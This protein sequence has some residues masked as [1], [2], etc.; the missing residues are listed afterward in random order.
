MTIEPPA[1]GRPTEGDGG[2]PSVPDDVW[3]RFVHDHEEDIRASAPVE[4]SARAR[5]VTARLRA[6]DEQAASAAR[7]KGL[8]RLPGARR[9][10]D[11]PPAQ[12]PG[13]RT[14]P[15]W[16]EMN[17]KA[18][19]KRRLRGGIG[20]LAAVAVVLFALN[21]G[22]V[23]SRLPGG[24]GKD[25]GTRPRDAAPL[26]AETARPTG[27][28]GDVPEEAPTLARPF[29]GS[30]A[31][32]YADGAAGIVLPEPRAVGAMSKDQVAAALQRTKDFLVASGLDPATLR[33]ERPAAALALLDPRQEDVS[34]FA[35]ASLARPDREH[36]PVLL[37]TRFDPKEA[38]LV[39]PTV[40]TR[41]RITFKEGK[42]GGVTVHADYTFVYALR[43][44]ARGSKEV[45][46]TIVRRVLDTELLDPER[47]QVTP[48]RLTLSSFDMEAGNS[49]CGRYDG[50]LHPVFPST[51]T[52]GHEPSGPAVDPYDRSRELDTGD[53]A[54]GGKGSGKTSGKDRRAECGTVSRS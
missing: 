5:M 8:G 28:P 30:P 38:V 48:D 54:D 3:E 43:K 53:G 31:Q 39:G 34:G 14:G 20:V 40:K 29:A 4:P 13:W 36:D 45:T 44:P 23:L 51:R 16:Q 33:G 11:V 37:F 26:A 10:K 25:D 15:A 7:R 46:R 22:A 47:Y 49:A 12:P 24:P 6:Q 2:R 35:T 9:R 21:P 32:S 19:R 27:A 50:Y 1:S 17:G 18:D 42:D 52:D 41:G